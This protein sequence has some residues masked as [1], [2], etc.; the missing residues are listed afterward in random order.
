MTTL[1]AAQQNFTS[2]VQDAVESGETTFHYDHDFELESVPPAIKALRPVAQVLHIDNCFRLAELHPGIGDLN[3]LRWLNV[4]YN[5]LTVL[6]SELSR[7]GRLERFHAGNNEIEALPLELWALK[8]LEELH[9]ENNRLRALPTYVLFLPK[10]RELLLENNPLLNSKEL[11]GAEAALHFPPIRTGDCASCSIRFHNSICFVT[12]HKICEHESV[13]IVHYVCS[14]R[15]KE[16]LQER[17][18][19][20]DVDLRA[21]EEA[22]HSPLRSRAD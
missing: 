22:Y 20:Y 21:K 1:T 3:Q 16:Q 10:L 12:F 2:K 8:S 7:L 11:E 15:C 13:P 5:K 17:L 19:Q 4:S 14:D 9:L 6:P 18:R